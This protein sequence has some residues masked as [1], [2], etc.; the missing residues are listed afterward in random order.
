MAV[1]VAV[2]AAVVSRLDYAPARPSRSPTVAASRRS[3]RILKEEGVYDVEKLRTIVLFEADFN[4][5]NKH[6]G[7]SMM[8]HCVKNNLISEEQYSIPG[9][10]C[11]DHALNRRLLFD[12]T[13]YNKNSTAMTPCDLKSCFDRIAHVPATLAM[14]SSSHLL[15]VDT[16]LFG[17]VQMMGDMFMHVLHYWAF[18]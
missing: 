11:V 9:K 16:T 5:N 10:K 18:E 14:A 3:I 2:V 8:Q 7:R 13:R 4:Q 12:I 6:L 15:F 17:I 1:A